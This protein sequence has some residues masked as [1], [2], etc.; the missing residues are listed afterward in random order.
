MPSYPAETPRLY[1]ETLT[2]AHLSDFH[3][4][5]DNDAGVLWSSKPKKNTVE[6]SKDWLVNYILPTEENWDIDKN[7]LLLKDGG[8]MIGEFFLLSFS[9]KGWGRVRI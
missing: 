7:A 5:W 9:M 4:L 6:E 2:L 3:E 1:L 8:K